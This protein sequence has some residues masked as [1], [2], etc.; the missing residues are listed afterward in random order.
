MGTDFRDLND[1]GRPDILFTALANETFPVFFNTGGGFDDAGFRTRLSILSRKKAGWSIAAADFDFDG[2]KDIFAAYS[3]VLSP[4]GTRGEAAK[5]AN[6]LYRQQDSGQFEDLSESSGLAARPAKMYRGAAVGDVNGDGLIDVVVTALN[7]PAELCL[8]RT[9]APGNSISIQLEGRDANRDGIGA[10]VLV[11]TGVAA[12]H[13]HLSRQ[14]GYASSSE[15]VLRFGLGAL[16]KAERIEIQWP[17]GKR[18]VIEGVAA[19]ATVRIRE[20]SATAG[21]P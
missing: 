1:D 12:H 9:A 21:E 4:Q 13:D 17:S 8:N 3:D 20:P 6:A 10:R 11:E 16:K 14:F 5:Q 2:R 15:G 19:G 7:A 18:Q